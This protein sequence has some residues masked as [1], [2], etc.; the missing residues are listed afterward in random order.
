MLTPY[1]SEE[2]GR[3]L[4]DQ[5]VCYAD[6]AG[7]AWLHHPG[8]ELYILVEG[9][10]RLTQ[11]KP[12]TIVAAGRAFR[13]SGLRVLFQL[14]NEPDLVRQPYRTIGER[15][16]TPVATIG[17]IIIDLVRQGYLVNEA[18]RQLRRREELI[19]RWVEGY[20]DT[21]RPRLPTVRYRWVHAQVAAGGWQ[22]L[23]LGAATRWGGSQPLIYC[24]QGIC[25]RNSLR[26]TVWL[27]GRR[28]C[29]S[30]G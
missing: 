22:H 6:A 7:N 26:F 11:P 4:R 8:A 29:G 15:T 23:P 5:N 27:P 9:R 12:V 25:N 17:L 18:P 20:G 28:S 13:K 30:W 24:W 2:V 3:Q 14:L 16:T 21:L 19:R 1:V 10:P